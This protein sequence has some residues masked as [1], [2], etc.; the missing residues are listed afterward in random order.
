MS[1]LIKSRTGV[2]ALVGI[3]AFVVF[4]LPTPHWIGWPA[5]VLAIA[6]LAHLIIVGDRRHSE[7]RSRLNIDDDT[8]ESSRKEQLVNLLEREKRDWRKR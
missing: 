5:L 1:D 8:D 3:V 4:A 6:S 2:I 7:L